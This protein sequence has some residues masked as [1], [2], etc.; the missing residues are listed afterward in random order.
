MLKKMT[1]FF[2]KS[3]LLKKESSKSSKK[4]TPNS[5]RKIAGIR[6]LK[7]FLLGNQP[8]IL[9]EKN[10]HFYIKSLKGRGFYKRARKISLKNNF[11]YD[12]TKKELFDLN[13]IESGLNLILTYRREYNKKKITIFA[14]SIDGLN[15]KE[16]AT[17]K[18]IEGPL[19]FVKKDYLAGE[20]S[21]YIGDNFIYYG[22]S[23]SFNNWSVAKAHVLT[24][25]QKFFDADKLK[26]VNTFVLPEGNFVL[27]DASFREGEHFRVQLGGAL[28][29]ADNP[30]ELKWR[31][32]RPI[33][34]QSLTGAEVETFYPLGAFWLK[35]KINAYFEVNGNLTVVELAIPKFETDKKISILKR[36]QGNP[37]LTPKKENAWE[38]KAV[39][40]AAAIY[41]ENR[42]HLIYRALG[43]DDVSTWGY[44]SSSDGIN[45][46]VRGE[47]PV[48][49]PKERFE[50]VVGEK[51][52]PC[53]HPAVYESGG[54]CNGGCEDPRMTRIGDRIYV[55]YVA[56]NGY[57]VPG[58]AVT[59]INHNDFVNNRW[60]W[61]RARLISKPGQI[62]KNWMIFPEKIAGRF[63]I[64]HSISPKIMID[65]FDSLDEEKIYIEKSFRQTDTQE[66]R[67]D[68]IV[69]GAGAPPIKT[70]YGWL[71]FY[72]AM[73]KKD[74]NRYKIGAMI[75]DYKEPEVVLY[76]S[77]F[78]ILEPDEKYEN[79]GFKAG[80]VYVCGAVVEKGILYIYY[81]GADMVMCVATAKLDDFLERLTSDKKT[82]LKKIKLKT[83]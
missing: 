42:F 4:S 28:F 21:A 72:H 15:F 22:Q 14:N 13:L 9:F 75:L 58:V 78:P 33:W 45:F 48:Y 70:K 46:D 37:I 38:S 69:R 19:A 53:S 25:R 20:F 31:S 6:F 60:S 12:V 56:Y 83:N 30:R 44:A 74:P 76:R 81:G 67:W 3:F 73:D 34:E 18:A 36:H 82:V 52:L 16:V 62:Q 23:S 29:S 63:A 11:G 79:E 77:R 7:V 65:Y 59:S 5:K 40:N 1:G 54:G 26:L 66:N 50:G 27:Y 51:Y 32:E 8:H 64:L 24:P 41:A 80:V 68:N 55:T 57:E 61:S 10:K 2:N 49:F 71:L 43:E 35:N 39:F 17:V 47:Y